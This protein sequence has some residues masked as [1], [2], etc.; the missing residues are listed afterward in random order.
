MRFDI[1]SRAVSGFEDPDVSGRALAEQ[2]REEP[3]VIACARNQPA[4]AIGDRRLVEIDRTPRRIDREQR[5]A[6]RR[7]VGR[8]PSDVA[9]RDA[10][11]RARHA[12]RIEDARLEEGVERLP[13]HD[14][15]HPP[16]QVESDR[17]A[18]ARSGLVNEW[19]FRQPVGELG[20][21]RRRPGRWQ[22]RDRQAGSPA[23]RRFP[24]RHR[25]S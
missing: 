12:E 13:R 5:A 1:A 11:A 18:P 23:R 9:R 4:A 8:E 6:H 25:L 2:H 24:H 17:I 3:V 14:L 20:E 15:D 22:P 7:I 21:A 10:K 16:H 19:Q